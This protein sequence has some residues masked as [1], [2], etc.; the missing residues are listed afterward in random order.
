MSDT[1]PALMSAETLLGLYARR[2]LSPVEALKSVP[3]GFQ[4]DNAEI[5]FVAEL[6]YAIHAVQGHNRLSVFRHNLM[7]S[8]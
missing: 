8:L 3:L 2:R 5:L 1:D 7:A 4:E 6:L